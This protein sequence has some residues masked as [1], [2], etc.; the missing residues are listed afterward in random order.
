MEKT[1]K[2]GMSAR[3]LARAVLAVPRWCRMAALVLALAYTADRGFSWE[4]QA[5]ALGKRMGDAMSCITFLPPPHDAN[6]RFGRRTPAAT[7]SASA[8]AW[9]SWTPPTGT[10]RCSCVATAAG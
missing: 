10:A 4:T 2:T 7:G 3:V 9:T 5:H 1:E 8:T 6:M